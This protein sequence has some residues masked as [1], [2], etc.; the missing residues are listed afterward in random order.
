MAYDPL[1]ILESAAFVEWP[2][3]SGR[4]LRSLVPRPLNKEQNT[5]LGAGPGDAT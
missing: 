1:K 5:G 3:A 2:S 4:L